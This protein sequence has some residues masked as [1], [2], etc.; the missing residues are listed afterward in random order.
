MILMILMPLM[1]EQWEPKVNHESE[2][3]KWT[4]LLAPV[5]HQN[6]RYKASEMANWIV[7]QWKA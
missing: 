3:L 1:Q 4:T 5:L 7:F 2:G 6:H